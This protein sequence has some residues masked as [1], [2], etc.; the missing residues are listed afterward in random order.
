MKRF[1]LLL[2]LLVLLISAPFGVSVAADFKIGVVDLQRCITESEEGKR[3]Y[4]DLKKKKDAMQSKLDERQDSLL[5]IKEELEKQSMML[6][7][8][9][10]EDK[11]KEF[12][13]RKREFKYLY[14]DLSDQMQKAEAEARE[15]MLK[16][17]ELVVQD[18]GVKGGFT[19]VFERRS[20]GIMYLEKAIDITEKVIEAYNKVK[21]QQP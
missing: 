18:I 6:S 10:K 20:S 5:K 7:M 14:E 16:D 9:A 4:Q 19:I 8:D 2:G 1:I 3:V 12:E 15:A 17:L 13:R 11:A 21:G